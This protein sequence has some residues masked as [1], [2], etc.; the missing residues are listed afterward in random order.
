MG[1]KRDREFLRGV[2]EQ[3]A[4]IADLQRRWPKAF[5]T[6]ARE[7]RPLVGSNIPLIHAEFGWSM[8]YIRGVLHVWKQRRAYCNAVLRYDLRRDLDGAPTGAVV[9]PAA[10]TMAQAQLDAHDA[11]R[12]KRIARD[13]GKDAK[14][15]A[16]P[17]AP[18]VER[19]AS[20]APKA[21]TTP[22]PP[23]PAPRRRPVLTLASMRGAS[24][25]ASASAG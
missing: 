12:Q 20:P 4:A 1:N 21:N 10:R 15:E 19:P 3:R 17:T 24:P 11:Q 25:T 16:A 6:D 5:P 18:V 8:S 9:G 22:E 2:N 13:A 23:P 7:V 14:V